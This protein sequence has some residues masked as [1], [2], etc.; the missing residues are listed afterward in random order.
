MVEIPLHVPR[1]SRPP[2]AGLLL[3]AALGTT[4][5][6][7]EAQESAAEPECL[8]TVYLRQIACEPEPAVE[9]HHPNYIALGRVVS[10][11]I[12]EG[13]SDDEVEAKFQ[14]SL[15]TQPLD[16]FRPL[17][18]AYTQRS[19]WILSCCS[20]PFRETNYNPEI[21]LDYYRNPLGRLPPGYAATGFRGFRLGLYEHASNGRGGSDA[22]DSVGWDRSYIELKFAFGGGLPDSLLWPARY[23]E[24]RTPAQER[25]LV[26]VYWKF[27]FFSRTSSPEGVD[28]EDTL[29]RAE[30]RAQLTSRDQQLTLRM[31]RGR[32]SGTFSYQ[33]D[34]AFGNPLARARPLLYVQYWNGVGE[35]LTEYN[36]RSQ[37]TLLGIMFTR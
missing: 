34:V 4:A 7:A 30:V 33:V 15:K 20:A 25:E 18:F 37:R 29:G 9:A 22:A 28:L 16:F 24:V 26:T 5:A 31:R 36:Q 11:P 21:Y 17:Y 32:R 10:E 2:W 3:A 6:G 13:H 1:W 35:S 8:R 19:F 23:A 12:A 27:S 14:I